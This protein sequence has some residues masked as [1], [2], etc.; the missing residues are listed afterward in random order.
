MSTR[1][2][3][4][5]PTPDDLL[6]AWIH[7]NPALVERITMD[8]CGYVKPVRGD[9]YY[10]QLQNALFRAMERDHASRREDAAA[11]RYH[12]MQDDR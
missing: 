1:G 7:D 12:D 9:C 2:R 11:D 3:Y 5:G 4:E 10:Q 8:V 6:A